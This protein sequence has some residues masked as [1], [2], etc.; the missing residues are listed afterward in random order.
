VDDRQPGTARGAGVLAALRSLLANGVELLRTRLELIRLELMEE[1]GRM[2]RLAVTL[3]IAG[4]FFALGTVTLT[5]FLIMLAGEANRLF[6]AGL[7]TLAYMAIGTIAALKARSLIAM[8]TKLFAVS[9]GELAKDR[10]ELR[11]K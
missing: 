3:A 5:I 11:S 1:R 2:V 10:D 9:L 4:F 6:A 7:L 8:G